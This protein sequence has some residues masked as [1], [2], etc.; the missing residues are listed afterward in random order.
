MVQEAANKWKD[1]GHQL[2]ADE[3]KGALNIIEADYRQDAAEC[4]K[5]MFQKWLETTTNATWDQVIEALEK[6][7]L[8]QL[9]STLSHQIGMT[10]V[11]HDFIQ[12]N[13][14]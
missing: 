12:P 11:N 3:Y 5:R 1:L 7:Q 14:L 6:I 2:L 10:I 9:A 13:R 4:C 8:I